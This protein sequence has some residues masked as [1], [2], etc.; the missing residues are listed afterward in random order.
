MYKSHY[1]S[2]LFNVFDHAFPDTSTER[3]AFAMMQYYPS[4][5]RLLFA[6]AD[7]GMGIPAAVNRYLRSINE[8]AV[9]AQE[10]LNDYVYGAYNHY[11]AHH[12]PERT[13]QCV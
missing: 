11:G 10:T 7:F 1:L 12:L 13:I 6:V 5:G 2:E 4:R 8:P 3:I 9:S